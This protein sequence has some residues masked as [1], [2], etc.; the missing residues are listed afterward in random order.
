MTLT[1]ELS[2]NGQPTG[3]YIASAA[4]DVTISNITNLY[5]DGT[6]NGGEATNPGGIVVEIDQ[7]DYMTNGG[8][9]H[10]ISGSNQIDSDPRRLNAS[11]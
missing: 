1:A 8:G 6:P 9:R 11:L 4:A 7:S 2:E 5:N 3:L 10:V